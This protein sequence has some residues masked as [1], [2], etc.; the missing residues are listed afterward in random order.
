VQVIDIE[1]RNAPRNQSPQ[2]SFRRTESDRRPA[3]VVRRANDGPTTEWHR[4]HREAAERAEKARVT[5]DVP[6]MEGYKLAMT[7]AAIAAS[8]QAEKL[9][10]LQ[11]LATGAGPYYIGNIV[12]AIGST[13]HRVSCHVRSLNSAGLVA[14][15]PG[16]RKTLIV[17]ITDA[18][19]AHLAGLGQ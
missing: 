3:D 17:T 16:P 12:E 4:Q 19:R 9:A 7:A 8:R 5:S 6:G 11:L 14:R 15:T 1:A 10:M 2:V 18:G 13:E